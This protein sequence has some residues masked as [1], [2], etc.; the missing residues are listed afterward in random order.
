MNHRRVFLK[1]IVAGAS[2][3]TLFWRS[4]GALPTA[5]ISSQKPHPRPQPRRR[6][7]WNNDGD[8]LWTTAHNWPGAPLYQSVDQYLGQRMKGKLDNTHVDSIFYNGHTNLPNWEFPTER[9]RILGPDPLRH[10]VEFAHQAGLEFMYSIRMNEFH[11]SVL[12]GEVRWS[13]FKRSHLEL[14]QGKVS[15][16][17]FQEK[18][19]PWA[20]RETSR[21]P[22]QDGLD[23]LFG[24]G[25]DFYSW[26]AYDYAL[27]QVRDYFLGVVEGAC[28]R[29][30][31]DGIELDW[32]RF[33][34]LFRFGEEQRNIPIM[35]DFIQQLRQRLRSYGEKR[36]RPILLAM[37]VPD[38]PELALSIG[39][40]VE[41]WLRRGWVDVVVAGFGFAPFTFPLGE[42][43]A[44]GHRHGAQVYGC[45]DHLV[46]V[47]HRLEAVRAAAQRFWAEGA[48]G[49]YVY[50]HIFNGLDEIGD[51]ARLSR[52]DKLYQVDPDAQASV[53]RE[54]SGHWYGW[55]GFYMGTW[56]G[57]LPRTFTTRSG[58]SS[59][60]FSLPIGDRPQFARRITLLS[61]WNPEAVPGR[62]SWRING[63]PAPDHAPHSVKPQQGRAWT[64]FEIDG[65]RQGINRLEVRV[66]SAAAR[67]VLEE[68]R[69]A[70]AYS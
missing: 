66:E 59:A 26:A 29:Y 8:D 9:I 38:S 18:I 43:V 56:P 63:R 49:V 53:A 34:Y 54:F 5:R 40:D 6:V 61:R 70:I 36:G 47:L 62:V 28:E 64:E 52:L 50:N 57:Q 14:L 3:P 32:G 58:P 27:D 68:V 39:L 60:R 4:S 48:D 45:M 12:P 17:E 46:P 25:R 33:P 67:S 51:P 7:I 69:V 24:G 41:E 20:R 37:R 55:G 19:L 21:H 11:C 42:W 30:D 31:L 15:A 16:Q 13:P 44:L 65:L 23:R 35:T 1:K 2:A 10:V 22:L